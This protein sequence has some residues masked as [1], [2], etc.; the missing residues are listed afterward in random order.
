MYRQRRHYVIAAVILFAFI[1]ALPHGRVGLVE[2]W[3]GG[4]KDSVSYFSGKSSSAMKLVARANSNFIEGDAQHDKWTATDSWVRY[5]S[6]GTS[7][8]R[9][10]PI[11]IIRWLDGDTVDVIY[12]KQT[13]RVR[14]LGVD[15]LETHINKK[16]KVDVQ[17]Y[18]KSA[19][20]LHR[21]GKAATKAAKSLLPPQ[22]HAGIS[23]EGK[24]PTKDVYGRVLGY[25][26]HPDG[27]VIN[28]YLVK[29]GFVRVPRVQ[30]KN[31]A[32]YKVLE[33]KARKDNKG[34]WKYLN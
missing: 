2:W 34:I 7:Y 12:N 29:G 22:K 11:E 19:S 15:A 33:L 27:Y 30:S 14:L 20:F 26:H 9:V 13:V 23:F 4:W 1:M 5:I 18:G 32:V 31:S 8:N 25:I 24:T 28:E 16:M 17:N 6:P 3:H 21:L 10:W